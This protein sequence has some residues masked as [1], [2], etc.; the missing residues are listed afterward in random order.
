MLPTAKSGSH[1]QIPCLP[2]FRAMRKNVALAVAAIM[3]APAIAGADTQDP[4]NFLAGAT[5]RYEDNLFRLNSPSDARI[6]LGNSQRSDWVYSEFGGIKIDKPYAQQRFQVDLTAFHSHNQT[7]H[8]LDFDGVNYRAAWLWQLTPHISGVLSADQS[9]SMT[10]F[11]DFRGTNSSLILNRRNVQTNESKVFSFDGELGAGIHLV[12]GAAKT[13]SRNTQ[14]FSAISDFV[15]DSVELGGKYVAPSGNSI[16]LVRREAQGDFQGRQLDVANQLD[17]GFDQHETEAKVVWKITGKSEIDGRLDYLE[18]EHNNFSSRDYSGF[19]GNV[20]YRWSPTG[21]LLVDVTLARNLTSFQEAA[22]SF[23]ETESFTIAPTWLLSAKTT[24]RMKYDY[25]DR[26]Y[27]GAIVFTPQMR[28]DKVQTL[29]LSADWNVTRSILV[30]GN[31][32]HENRAS[33]ISGLSYKANVIGVNAQ[34]LF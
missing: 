13:Q 26:D 15:Q 29:L 24:I 5:A 34:I 32:Q 27:R 22:D 28:E 12:G 23:Y 2:K 6:L 33:N 16:S 14:N 11:S 30:S 8:F 10:P 20:T 21:K 18:R 1:K 3:L 25:S 31:V 7:Y 4:F 9:Q 19:V 17:T